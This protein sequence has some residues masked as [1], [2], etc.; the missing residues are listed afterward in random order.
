MN[1]VV[2]DLLVSALDRHVS[3]EYDPLV[4]GARRERNELT[5]ARFTVARLVLQVGTDEVCAHSDLVQGRQDVTPSRIALAGEVESSLTGQYE[6]SY[7]AAERR[8]LT[9]GNDD[10]DH[11]VAL[12]LRFVDEERRHRL[13]SVDRPPRELAGAGMGRVCH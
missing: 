7:L 13:E 5:Q 8:L 10:G 12:R 4:S 2:E 9:W 6:G 1:G 3:L 11:E